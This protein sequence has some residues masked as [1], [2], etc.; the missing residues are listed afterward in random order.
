MA[1][2][3][4]LL[5]IG[6]AQ[7][8]TD[9]SS[10]S[11]FNQIG[12]N[13]GVSIVD[14]NQ[15]G[16]EDFYISRKGKE[17][18][19]YI[20]Q[21][22]FSF[23]EMGADYGLNLIDDTTGSLW[24]DF[25]NDRDMD[26][27]IL[28]QF[29]ASKL[30]E[31][32][33]GQ[34]V[35]VSFLKG[36]NINGNIQSFNAVDFD[37][38]GDLDIYCGSFVSENYLLINE[39][40][41]FYNYTTPSG[42]GNAEKS[43][44]S[45]FFDYDDDGDQDL[46]QVRD[47]N[48]GNLFYRND[49][50]YFTDATDLTNTG[51]HGQG[52]GVDVAD[53][54]NDGKLDIYFS[55][56]LENVLYV[57]NDFGSFEQ[58]QN[59]LTDD[60][61]MGW[62]TLIFDSNNN[63]F[64]DIYIA[65]DSHFLVEGEMYPNKLLVNQGD[66]SFS[67]P[68]MDAL[69]NNDFASYGA[70]TG[71]LNNDGKLDIVIAN[72][73]TEGIQVFQNTSSAK[74][75]LKCALIGDES[76]SY[77]IGAR[78]ELTSANGVYVEEIKCGSSYVS[79]NSLKVHFG[80]GNTEIITELKIKWPSGKVQVF[81]N[82][83]VNQDLLIHENLGLMGGGPVVYTDPPFPTQTDDI[84]V[85]FDASQGNA[86]LSGFTGNVYAHTGVITSESTAPNDWKH[87]QGNWGTAD[88]NVIMTNEGD[89][90]YSLSYNIEDYYSINVGEVVEQLAF[91][92]RNADGSIVG[93]EID[94]G[95]I[96]HDVYPP[97]E[98]LLVNVISPNSDGEIIYL[99]DSLN[100]NIEI[101]KTA[102]LVIKDNGNI[103]FQDSVDQYD[104]YVYGTT[105]GAH[106]LSF[107]LSTPTEDAFVER[108]Y[109]VLDNNEDL[110]DPPVGVKP[111]LNHFTNSSLIFSLTA[112]LKNHV[113]LL[114]PENEFKVD[115]NYKLKKSID[116]TQYWIELPKS[117]FADG[118]NSYQYLIDG[119]IRIADPY[120]TVVLDP[121]N[122]DEVPEDVMIELPSYPEGLTSGIVSAFDLDPVDYPWQVDEVEK[123]DNANLVIY[124]ILMRDF[125][126]DKNF[127][128]LLDTLDYLE[129]LGIN[130]IELMPIQEFEGNQSWGYNPNFHMAVDK[131]YGSRDQ[132][133]AVIDECHKRGI[134]VILDVVFN[135]AFSQ[136]PLCQMYWDPAAFRP[137]EES[138]YLNVE[139]KHPFN[140]GYDFNH[141]SIYTREWVKRILD[142]WIT[143][144]KFDGFRFDL[145][146]GFTQ[147]F[148]G[149][150]VGAWGQYDFTR[151]NILTDYA[152][153]IWSLDESAYVILEHFADN[154]EEQELSSRGMMLWGNI[155]HDYSEGAMGYSS[156]L[157]WSDYT[158][159]GWTEPNLIAYMESHDEE[160]MG[161]KLKTWGN[162]NAQY[163]TRDLATGVER[164][165]AASTIY[166]SIPGPKMLWQFGELHYDYSINRC[167]NGSIN[168]S[169]RLDPKP[170]R[171]DYFA[172]PSRNELYEK[173]SAL[174]YLKTNY[175]TFSTTDFEF[176]DNNTF[177]KRV[178]LNHSDMDAV[179]LA[180]FRISESEVNPKFP[181]PGTWF[182][183]FTGNELNVVDTEQAI[184]FQPGEYRIYTSEM[185]TPPNG[186]FTSTN[187]IVDRN[188]KMFPNPIATGQSIVISGEKLDG[189]ERVYL[190]NFDGRKTLLNFLNN[191][192]EIRINIPDGIPAG[193]YNVV[194]VD[195]N[196]YLSEK[197]VLVD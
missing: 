39:N 20:N 161:Y 168:E 33:N 89:D 24:F 85:Y 81:E 155:S 107:E 188:L 10:E 141:E 37:N 148:S 131:Y 64:K 172:E 133:R 197:L 5:M 176:N 87:V 61:G 177:V 190:E 66:L 127:K 71:D 106:V 94:G 57:Q 55:N 51:Y 156:N 54:N 96:F 158:Q 8:F 189:F 173:I 98:G 111:G 116:G 152:D 56:L 123:V 59:Q 185:I 119:N 196:D 29:Q 14:I 30:F 182:E 44:G 104:D 129:N 80:L 22:D 175:P 164:V 40:G 97:N 147:K 102:W 26:V 132:L 167:T 194:L 181:Y 83:E 16:K 12:Q 52:M 90:L 128:S 76:N 114:C 99:N 11:L 19:L 124:E 36:I 121:W 159:R 160:R 32:Q 150:N 166:M 120:S 118:K 25:D 34:F 53:I 134:M 31:N 63:G 69:L 38:D 6:K 125:L 130:A 184:L 84:T 95:D 149:A 110:Q 78:L 3:S 91:V 183:Y 9:V 58:I 101:N 88:P 113:F 145:S 143:E 4:F 138:P 126:S 108:N 68:N 41:Q 135:H 137:T 163:D 77:G 179:S 1:F 46:Y 157:N 2:Q 86:A 43:I 195:N 27:L 7:S 171:W 109:F 146:K 79:Q 18:L 74:N 103:V 192:F 42:I 178:Q 65:N 170:V 75:Y 35:D 45:V 60:K 122:D 17:N 70:A 100:V 151:V 21:G 67:A 144:Y 191:G 82:I 13:R 105:I 23:N 142:H 169:C 187:E 186:F 50:G 15:D 112:P 73:A 47:G 140:V 174:N 139:A 72:S 193:I 165:V 154:S 48:E 162:S 28:N 153:H 62:G 136:S 93:R 115:I 92:F 49:G 180:N 117:L